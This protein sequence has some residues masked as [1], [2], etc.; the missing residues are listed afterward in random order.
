[1][2]GPGKSI[3]FGMKILI[4]LTEIGQYDYYL[5]NYTG[6]LAVTLFIYFTRSNLFLMDLLRHTWYSAADE[7][8]S[9]RTYWVKRYS[10]LS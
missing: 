2:E 4:V 8:L 1:M 9:I 3:L 5:R 10:Q 7:R 6:E